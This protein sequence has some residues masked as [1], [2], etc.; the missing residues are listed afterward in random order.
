MKR[1]LLV[2]SGLLIFIV[3]GLG[4]IYSRVVSSP[5]MVILLVV[6]GLSA[7]VIGRERQGE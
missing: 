2:V 3:I 6:F 5:M 7:F 1:I 4:F